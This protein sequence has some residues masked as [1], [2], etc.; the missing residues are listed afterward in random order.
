MKQVKQRDFQH[1][2]CQYRDQEIEVIGRNGKLIGYWLPSSRK[3]EKYKE[4]E[5]MSTEQT[6][7]RTEKICTAIEGGKD[8]VQISHAV[9]QCDFCNCM[10]NTLWY[11]WEDGEEWKICKN[12]VSTTCAPSELKQKLRSMKKVE[13]QPPQEAQATETVPMKPTARFGNFNP[14]PKPVKKKKK[15]REYLTK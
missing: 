10:K 5:G 14:Q 6:L 3:I 2:F 4:P 8:E 15:K 1:D 13:I 9:D 11:K 12:C 7:E